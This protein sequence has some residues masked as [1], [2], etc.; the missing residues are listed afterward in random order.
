MRQGDVV[1]ALR[2]GVNACFAHL[3]AC[4]AFL[5]ALDLVMLGE[6]VVQPLLWVMKLGEEGN[7]DHV[8]PREAVDP[9]RGPEPSDKLFGP[10]DPVDEFGGPGP[11]LNGPGDLQEALPACPSDMSPSLSPRQRF[12]LQCLIQGDSNKHIARKIA[13]SEGTVKC[14]LKTL[15]KKM[16][17]R[18]RTQAAIWAVSHRADLIE[19]GTEDENVGA[20][21]LNGSNGSGRRE[22]L[23]RRDANGFATAVAKWTFVDGIGRSL[24]WQRVEGG[25]ASHDWRTLVRR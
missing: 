14:H 5:K 22:V 23:P 20:P 7:A 2:A 1:T 8:G 17:L 3:T 15:L 19:P 18:N 13:V 9:D 4:D 16:Q 21:T 10:D 12:I 11:D 25:R 6:T 24:S